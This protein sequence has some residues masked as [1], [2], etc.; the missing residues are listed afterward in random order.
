ME[1]YADLYYEYY[2]KT[3]NYFEEHNN[4]D[5]INYFLRILD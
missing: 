1:L 3:L 2:N 4:K 5:A